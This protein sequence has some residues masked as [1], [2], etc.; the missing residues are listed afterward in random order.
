MV[1]Q[2]VVSGVLETAAATALVGAAATAFSITARSKSETTKRRYVAAAAAV[3]AG[4]VH[5]GRAVQGFSGG[6]EQSL[7][8][9]YTYVMG[10]IPDLSSPLTWC[11][12]VSRRSSSACL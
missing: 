3:F 11:G 10:W 12:A 5:A 9:N 6:S 2:S 8:A 1:S 7:A 4:F